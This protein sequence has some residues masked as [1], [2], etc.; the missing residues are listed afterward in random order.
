MSADAVDVFAS[1]V[2]ADLRL[3]RELLDTAGRAEL[4]AAVVRRAR[5]EGLD[6]NPDDV[7]EALRASRRDWLARW[8]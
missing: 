7:E 3:H 6:V 2:V 5:A 1:L 8:V 4:V